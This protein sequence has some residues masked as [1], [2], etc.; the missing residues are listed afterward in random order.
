MFLRAACGRKYERCLPALG[1]VG[2]VDSFAERTQ[3]DPALTKLTNG[4]HDLGSGASKPVDADNDDGVALACVVQERGEA[5]RC[6]RVEVPDS[7]SL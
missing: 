3:D 1:C 7:L 2:C 6:S 5:G 4:G